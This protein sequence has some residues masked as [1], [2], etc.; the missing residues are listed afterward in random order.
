M[1]IT[2]D[3]VSSNLGLEI[4]AGRR[5]VRRKQAKRAKRDFSLRPPTGLNVLLQRAQ[6]V[7]ARIRSRGLS[8][9]LPEYTVSFSSPAEF[10]FALSSRT[11]FP[12][13]KLNIMM[14]RS[15]EDLRIMASNIRQV[16][17]HFAE[18]LA[19][20]LH[21]P[22][23]ITELLRGIEIRLFSRDHQWR[24]IAAALNGLGPALRCLQA[25]CP[26]EVHAVPGVPTGHVA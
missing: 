4:S 7:T 5:P 26:S 18:V 22:E 3:D 13:R 15:T 12:V 25:G 23:R 24:D 1:S 20:S 11:D 8:L 21:Q 10:E 19:Q 17:K 9:E 16:E 6:E 2:T 14:R